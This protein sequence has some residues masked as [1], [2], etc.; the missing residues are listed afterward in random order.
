MIGSRRIGFALRIASL[1][2]IAPATLKANSEE[3]TAWYEPPTSS[4][5]TSTSGYPAS[6]P[7]PVA[8]FMPRSTAGMYSLGISPPC[9]L[10]SVSYTHLRAH[11]TRHDLVCRLLLE[12]KKKQR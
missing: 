5:L 9:I 10:F 7:E 11:E 6:T 4:A 3:S 2:A 8:S 1:S 12:K